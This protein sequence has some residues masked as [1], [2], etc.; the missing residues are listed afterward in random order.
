MKTCCPNKNTFERKGKIIYCQDDTSLFISESLSISVNNDGLIHEGLALDSWCS[1]L[2]QS[3]I[4]LGWFVL[5]AK[6]STEHCIIQPF[7]SAANPQIKAARL[8]SACTTKNRRCFVVCLHFYL[9]NN[10]NV[11]GA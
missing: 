6:G 11:S 10:T 8:I 5:S 7:Y 4:I 3:R 2:L 1:S 9:N